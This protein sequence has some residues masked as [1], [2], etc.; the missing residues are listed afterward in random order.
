MK[1]NSLLL[2]IVMLVVTSLIQAQNAVIHIKNPSFEAEDY[3]QFF[4]KDA[5]SWIDCGFFAEE[6]PTI[7]PGS[8]EVELQPQ[9]LKGYLSMVVRENNTWDAVGQTLERPLEA[10]KCYK[11]SLYLATAERYVSQ[12]RI[13]GGRVNYRN[14]IRLLIWGGDNVCE[15]GQILAKTDLVKNNN[16]TLYEFVFHPKAT[17]THLALHAYYLNPMSLSY[18]GNILIDHASDIEEITCP[19]EFP[20]VENESLIELKPRS[21]EELENFIRLHGPSI[22]FNENGNELVGYEENWLYNAEHWSQIYF[23]VIGKSIQH[24]PTHQLVIAVKGKSP[25]KIQRRI[26]FIG[27]FLNQLGI[28]ATAYRCIPHPATEEAWL[29][30]NR[31]LTIRLEPKPELKSLKS[32]K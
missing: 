1:K 8:H 29:S 17:I 14:P 32:T 3:A 10:G 23:S 22:V 2:L 15:A 31:D 28:P 21:L 13:T 27:A 5:R 24:F 19:D 4:N 20:L 25:R 6:P 9:H 7:Q 11:F 12:S 30:T 26:E 18:N 16:W